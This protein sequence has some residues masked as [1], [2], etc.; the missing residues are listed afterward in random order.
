M[1]L[2]QRLTDYR[3]FVASSLRLEKARDAVVQSCSKMN[4]WLLEKERPIQFS[5]F[6]FERDTDI[7][8]WQEAVKAQDAINAKMTDCVFFVLITDGMIGNMSIVE[9][10][11]AHRF[12]EDDKFPAYIL[13]FKRVDGEGNDKNVSLE[14]GGLSYS[15]FEKKYLSNVLLTP[16]GGKEEYLSIYSIPYVTEQDITEKLCFNLKRFLRSPRRPFIRAERG[17]KINEA[18]FYPE[19]DRLGNVEGKEHVYFSRGFDRELAWHISQDRMIF[20]HGESLSGKTRALLNLCHNN[21]DSW[22]FFMP[23]AESISESGQ[24]LFVRIMNEL[25]DYLRG[26]ELKQKLF[27]IID[28]FDKY[29]F[30]SDLYHRT[31]RTLLFSAKDA[32]NCYFLI[33]SSIPPKEL[34]CYELLKKFES[35]SGSVIFSVGI[36]PMSR[37]EFLAAVRFF[38]HVGVLIKEENYLYRTTG[39]LLIDLEQKKSGYSDYLKNHPDSLFLSKA[40][41]AMSIWR[42]RNR[43]RIDIILDFAFYL[44]FKDQVG[45][46]FLKEE[47]ER[48]QERLY[49]SPRQAEIEAENSLKEKLKNELEGMIR[50][51]G[52][53]GFANEDN[54]D[55]LRIEEY[56]YRYFIGFDG[57]EKSPGNDTPDAEWKLIRAIMDYCGY[58]QRKAEREGTDTTDLFPMIGDLAKILSRC[59]QKYASIQRKRVLDMWQDD[60]K[61]DNEDREWFDSVKNYRKYVENGRFPKDD[62]KHYYSVIFK[63]SLFDA[64]DYAE[65]KSLF[66]RTDPELRDEYLLGALI[67]RAKTTEDFETIK[68]TGT[69]L[70][71]KDYPFII[72]RVC[73]FGESFTGRMMGLTKFT[74]PSYEKY[75]RVFQI[76]N[77]GK[78][79]DVEDDIDAWRICSIGVEMIEKALRLVTSDDEFNTV[80]NWAREHLYLFIKDEA[81]MKRW[82]GINPENLTRLEILSLFSMGATKMLW[83]SY[84]G[85]NLERLS[86]V[87]R[88]EI[89]GQFPQAVKNGFLGIENLRNR[90]AEMGSEMINVCSGYYFSEVYQKLFSQLETKHSDKRIVFRDIYTYSF[91]LDTHDCDF[92]HALSMIRGDLLP[93][94]KDKNN[95]I[96]VSLMLINKLAKKIKDKGNEGFRQIRKVMRLC[97]ALGMSM[98]SYTYNTLISLS[99]YPHGKMLLEQMK[100]PIVPDSFSFGGLIKT[101]P[102]LATA[103]SYFYSPGK[104]D[105]PI[106]FPNGFLRDV[107][108][109]NEYLDNLRE[110]LM[111]TQELWVEVFRKKCY[112]ETERKLIRSLF[113]W[114]LSSKDHSYL[115]ERGFL[116]NSIL[117]NETLIH[118]WREA[119]Q[120]MSTYP[121]LHDPITLCTLLRIIRETC[122]LSEQEKINLIN[123]QFEHA[124]RE[125]RL[126]RN[127]RF[128]FNI[129]ISFYSDMS[130]K[131]RFVFPDQSRGFVTKE[132]TPLEYIEEMIRCG[133][134]INEF[135]I[136][137]LR[138]CKGW[139]REFFEKLLE[140]MGNYPQLKRYQYTLLQLGSYLSKL[141]DDSLERR[142]LEDEDNGFGLKRYVSEY[143]R[144]IKNR[145]VNLSGKD[146]ALL[147]ILK[148]ELSRLNPADQ[149]S[150]MISANDMLTKLANRTG[151]S[152]EDIWS[153]YRSHFQGSFIPSS[154]T[155]PILAKKAPD[156]QTILTRIIPEI[157]R[158]NDILKERHSPKESW[159]HYPSALLSE[160]FKRAKSVDEIIED[161]KLFKGLSKDY[162]QALAAE[163]LLYHLY[164]L[165][166]KCFDSRANDVLK[167]YSNYLFFEHTP[168]DKDSLPD[169]KWM[170]DCLNRR[171]ITNVGLTNILRYLKPNLNTNKT[172]RM[173]V[174]NQLCTDYGSQ[175]FAENGILQKS[176]VKYKIF[177]PNELFERLCIMNGRGDIQQEVIFGTFSNLNCWNQYAREIE[178]LHKAGVTNVGLPLVD[179]I[180][181]FF[182]KQNCY[183][184]ASQIRQ[185]INKCKKN[186]S[187]ILFGFLLPDFSD[188]LLIEDWWSRSVVLD[189]LNQVVEYVSP[190]N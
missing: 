65:A 174:L 37:S 151:T 161:V 23:R 60:S 112:T 54:K 27:I 82:G 97:K 58:R 86:V 162:I 81:V 133:C 69:Y 89:I 41:K 33:T 57:K 115:A 66:D 3:I 187:P 103:L 190:A 135:T 134:P 138:N 68:N 13:I 9:Y 85:G 142:F 149:Y 141:L 165:N 67:T 182:D 50:T 10:I 106:Q 30:T 169:F 164:Q 143:N 6:L 15:A 22:F 157:K 121:F 147:D 21:A 39:A 150:A 110:N 2:N 92:V 90:I 180:L 126:D 168:L 172:M 95:P 155:I 42:D 88:D 109:G 28:D 179:G 93:H 19:K 101:A 120:F 127:D 158:W 144:Y 119:N 18:D 156:A 140:M 12:F 124:W 129:R 46:A 99:S 177:Y 62:L 176:I 24:H 61:V 131:I 74:F 118:D 181:A 146:G 91:M 137:G 64:K 83:R 116:H 32:A 178:L 159:L 163:N 48:L 175:L 55:I 75:Y 29:V 94:S 125:N 53:I 79:P 80:L 16:E 40:F 100:K 87:L 76:I 96:V 153:L 160:L 188:E 14:E 47:K 20:I 152:F 26:M 108:E 7:V 183:G 63:W 45:K 36:P 78:K 132:L 51:L 59:E 56:V 5:T 105:P 31:L 43:G 166:K 102:D 111:S 185:R 170:F 104:Q 122:S 139:T 189:P 171:T 123:R 1:D 25:S 38:N 17:N 136:I 73:D 173:E 184:K 145:V 72:N 84:Y 186:R 130:E 107:C 154:D 114:I 98:D 117:A 148:R 52:G 44:Y 113:D 49:Y 4:E 11:T 34:S 71:Y 77:L 70:R 8:Q 167:A 128:Y 35:E